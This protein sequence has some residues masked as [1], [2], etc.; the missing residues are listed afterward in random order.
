[1]VVQMVFRKTQVI[2]LEHIQYDL[3][4]NKPFLKLFLI[5]CPQRKESDQEL[6]LE[7]EIELK[8]IYFFSNKIS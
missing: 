1:M 6:M 5:K 3:N 2:T 8:G 4:I 7:K